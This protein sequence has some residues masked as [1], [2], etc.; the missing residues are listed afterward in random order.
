MLFQGTHM[1][2]FVFFLHRRHLTACVTH[3]PEPLDHG[4][5]RPHHVGPWNIQIEISPPL[6]P[7]SA[8]WVG[9][10]SAGEPCLHIPTP[11]PDIPK[12]RH[13]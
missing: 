12:C 2:F 1:G 6:R 8:V 13:K 7:P 4:G 10:R 11:P 3:Q 5:Q 9:I